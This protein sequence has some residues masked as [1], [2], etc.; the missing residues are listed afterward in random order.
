[1]AITIINDCQDGNAIARQEVMIANLFTSWISPTPHITSIGIGFGNTIE[2]AGN[3]IDIIGVSDDSGFGGTLFVNAAPRHRGTKKWLNGTPFAGFFAKECLVISTVDE[4][5]LSLI[6]KFKLTDSVELYDVPNVMDW[7]IDTK[8]L[9]A[10]LANR[11]KV[12]QFRSLEFTPR[13]A[14]WIYEGKEIPSTTYSIDKIPDAPFTIWYID[15]FGNCKT[16][17]LPEDVG[18]EPG[19]KVEVKGRQIMCYEYLKDVPKGELAIIQGSSGIGDKK[20]LEIV[21]NG[22]NAAKVLGAKVGHLI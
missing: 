14:K 12:S 10:Q 16:T 17:L 5:T 22:D 11:I 8:T 9:P 19:K 7:A 21:I 6:K 2:A 13:V 15:V 20:F 18:F 4:Y 1:M 3:M